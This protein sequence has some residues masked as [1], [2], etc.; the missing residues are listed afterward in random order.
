MELELLTLKFLIFYIGFM[1]TFD[2]FWFFLLRGNLTNLDLETIFNGLE[3]KISIGAI[4]EIPIEINPED[5][6]SEKFAFYK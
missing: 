3:K 6:I 5:L 4:K 2:F 1:I